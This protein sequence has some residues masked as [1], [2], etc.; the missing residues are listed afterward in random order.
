MEKYYLIERHQ[1]TDSKSLVNPQQYKNKEIHASVYHGQTAEKD[2]IMKTGRAK[3]H[4][5]FWGIIR[6]TADFLTNYR[7]Q[8]TME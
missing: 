2:K 8:K 5:T 1:P 4:I 7:S 6:Q 3:R